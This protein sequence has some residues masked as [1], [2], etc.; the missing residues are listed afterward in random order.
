MR[1]RHTEQ[2]YRRILLEYLQEVIEEILV[3]GGVLRVISLEHR[4]IEARDFLRL[5]REMNGFA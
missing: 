2:T 3:K 4:A 1:R 5:W